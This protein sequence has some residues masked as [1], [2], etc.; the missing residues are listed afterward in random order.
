MSD[1]RW[2]DG[3]SVGVVEFDDDHRRMIALLREI[4]DAVHRGETTKAVQLSNQLATLAADHI[5]REE[6]FLQR[7]G[8]PGT[9]TVIGAQKENLGRIAALATRLMANP[10]DGADIAIAMSDAFVAYLLRG[11][12][13]YKSYVEMTGMSDTR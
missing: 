1:F 6:A 3:M 11:D 13:N 9:D 2:L 7:I 8:F 12:I 4:S 5:A 10:Q